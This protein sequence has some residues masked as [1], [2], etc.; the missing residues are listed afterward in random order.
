MLNA[1]NWR[2]REKATLLTLLLDFIRDYRATL[3]SPR[4]QSYKLW[5]KLQ[6]L[7]LFRFTGAKIAFSGGPIF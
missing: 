3:F 1:T 5:G 6:N 4:G 7:S 2:Y